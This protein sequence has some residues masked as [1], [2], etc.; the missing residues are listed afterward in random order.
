MSNELTQKQTTEI[1]TNGDWGRDQLELLKRTICKGA[2]DDEFQLFVHVAKRSGLDPF[3]KQ[4]HAVKRWNTKENRFEMAIQTG[5]DGY[6]LIADR[7][8][9]YAGSDDAIFDDE[10][11][12]KKASVTVH[13]FVKGVKCSFT[14]TARW[15][16][17][18]PKPPQDMM[19]KKMPCVMLAKV[20]ECL[21]LRKAFPADLSGLYGEEEMDQAGEAVEYQHEPVIQSS[22]ASTFIKQ[23]EPKVVV[24]SRGIIG[25]EIMAEYKRLNLDSQGLSEWASNAFHKTSL[26]DLT[27]AEMEKLLSE[28]KAEKSQGTFEDFTDERNVK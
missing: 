19:W 3:A 12:P 27:I 5:I 23:E 25:S 15:Q 18:C 20:A 14:A 7:T 24:R 1:S 10:N 28:M 6:R 17:Y 8:G 11:E 21:A 4:I 22:P 9:L 13:K 16:E 26:K 2:S